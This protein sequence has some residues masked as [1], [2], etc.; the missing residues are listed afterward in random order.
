MAEKSGI[1]VYRPTDT[2]LSSSG[3]VGDLKPIALEAVFKEEKNGISQVTLKLPYD[4]QKRWQACKVGNILKVMVPVRVPPV[5]KDHEFAD[6]VEVYR[7]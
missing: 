3:L 2:D 4:E 6:K 1:Y 5:V 7:T